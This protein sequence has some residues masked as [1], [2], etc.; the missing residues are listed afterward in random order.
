MFRL[1]FVFVALALIV[2]PAM[3]FAD[4]PVPTINDSAEARLQYMQSSGESYIANVGEKGSVKFRKEPILRFTNPVSGV[5]D[6]G[7]FVWQDEFECPVAV[8]QIFIIPKTEKLWLH[9]FQSLTVD[10]LTFDYHGRTVWSPKSPGIKFEAIS[11]VSEPSNKAAARL[12]Q[13]RQIASRFSVKDDFE[14]A[15]ADELRLLP[16]PLVRYSNEKVV[17]GGLFAYAHGTDP[18]LL[19]LIEAQ[20]VEALKTD[21]SDDKQKSVWRVALAPMTAYAMTAKL[22]GQD[23]WSVDWRQSPRTSDIFKNFLFPPQ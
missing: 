20:K 16:Q 6:G 22:D 21:K 18:E 2:A 5:V 4:S 8:A 3:L 19:L 17:D 12:T 23:F 14:G 10:S 15:K 9:E 1:R 7:L 13:M 11:N